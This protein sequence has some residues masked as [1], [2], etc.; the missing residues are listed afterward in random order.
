MEVETD[1]ERGR[2]T[3][4]PFL[5]LLIL[6]FKLGQHGQRQMYQSEALQEV[7]EGD[8]WVSRIL[9]VRILKESSSSPTYGH[10]G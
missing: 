8:S 2:T 4:L 10:A 9:G 6:A 7:E 1:G 3:L 5:P